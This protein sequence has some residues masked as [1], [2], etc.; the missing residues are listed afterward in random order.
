MIA[1]DLAEDAEAQRPFA[2][3]SIGRDGQLETPTPANNEADQPLK[4][5]ANLSHNPHTHAAVSQFLIQRRRRR[6]ATFAKDEF[7]ARLQ[8]RNMSWDNASRLRE[9]A[10]VFTACKMCEPAFNIHYQ[11]WSKLRLSDHCP[12]GMKPNLVQ[13]QLIACARTAS[14]PKNLATVQTMLEEYIE[15][16]LGK[17]TNHSFVLLCALLAEV[18]VKQNDKLAA[19]V[20]YSSILPLASPSMLPVGAQAYCPDVVADLH[21]LRLFA[22]SFLKRKESLPHGSFD[23]HPDILGEL[24]SYLKEVWLMTA[25]S[26]YDTIEEIVGWCCC[27]LKAPEP[28]ELLALERFELE[29][30]ASSLPAI[31]KKKL[32]TVALVFS[33]LLGRLFLASHLNDHSSR[34]YLRKPIDTLLRDI[35]MYEVS[36][37]PAHA[38]SGADILWTISTMIAEDMY[39]EDAMMSSRLTVALILRKASIL[40]ASLQKL[41]KR[42]FLD[43]LFKTLPASSADSWLRPMGQLPGNIQWAPP[44]FVSMCIEQVVQAWLNVKIEDTSVSLGSISDSSYKPRSFLAPEQSVEEI[45]VLSRPASSEA[46]ISKQE[47]ML[48]PLKAGNAESI[49]TSTHSS[50]TRSSMR[51]F[52][53]FAE[54]VRRINESHLQASSASTDLPSTA[55]NEEGTDLCNDASFVDFLSDQVSACSI[56]PRNSIQSGVEENASLRFSAKSE[57]DLTKDME[58]F[59]QFYEAFDKIFQ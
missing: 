23:D 31:W 12:W 8:I 14:T 19:H 15:T 6:S 21:L 49:R 2:S 46:D 9:A 20:I 29:R 5:P 3:E 56:S 34:R 11:V 24:R 1:I 41:E 27:Q 32:T 48:T 4:F 39:T 58:K 25:E 40:T 16:I 30:I 7:E 36:F 28:H 43:H 33:F 47:S 35:K 44:K 57:A 53:R 59:S 54:Y 13:D 26:Q 18:Q 50:S 45:F 52:R 38:T 42:A 51:S 10:E 17:E 22:Y 55:Y 37:R